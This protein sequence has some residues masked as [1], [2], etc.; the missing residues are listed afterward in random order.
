[1]KRLIF[2]L[3]S[4]LFINYS[5]AGIVNENSKKWMKID[6]SLLIDTKSFNIESPLM[7][8]WIKNQ[9]YGKRRL[10]INCST[11]EERERYKQLKT[12]WGPILSMSPK[13]KILNQLCFLTK[14][15]N[16]TKERKPPNWAKNI[17]RNYEK[18]LLAI[19]DI[20]K[21]INSEIIQGAKTRSFID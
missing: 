17:I 21:K 9:N 20:N 19:D 16:F 12:E 13:Y 5:Y 7:F 4:S 6:E 2:L 10:T 14:I 3:I 18:N 1:M 15:D 8:F 11:F